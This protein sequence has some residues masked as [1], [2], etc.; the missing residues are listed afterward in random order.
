MYLYLFLNIFCSFRRLEDVT[1]REHLLKNFFIDV[2][3]TNI[4]PILFFISALQP[5]YLVSVKGVLNKTRND[6]KPPETTQKVIETTC[7]HPKTTW[8]LLKPLL[9]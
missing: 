1:P 5:V 4:K 9:T 8:N 2:L 3:I 7:N 6:L